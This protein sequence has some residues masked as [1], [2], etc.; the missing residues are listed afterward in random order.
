MATRM[1]QLDRWARALA[2]SN[3][4]DA[5]AALNA[6]ASRLAEMAHM[7]LRVRAT[8]QHAPDADITAALKEANLTA[9]RLYGATNLV[10]QKFEAHERGGQ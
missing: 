9:I 3:D 10:R 5:I 2:V 7:T 8:L 1:T 4:T 6:L